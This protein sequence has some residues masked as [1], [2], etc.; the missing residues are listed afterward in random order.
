V[1]SIPSSPGQDKSEGL[2]DA[3]V[4]DARDSRPASSEVQAS[5][6]QAVPATA[7]LLVVRVERVVAAEREA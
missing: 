6:W 2:T 1:N 4:D 5:T 7:A 3:P